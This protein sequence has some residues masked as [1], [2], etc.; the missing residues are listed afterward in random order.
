VALDISLLCRT[1]FFQAGEKLLE[2]KSPDRRT[3]NL[4]GMI[5][6]ILTFITDRFIY[7]LPSSLYVIIMLIVMVF[8]FGGI[9]NRK[10]EKSNGK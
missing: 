7:K 10:Q 8:M 4:I 2:R 1:G 3:M 9:W 5:I 6:F